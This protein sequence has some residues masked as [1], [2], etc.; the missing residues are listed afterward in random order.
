MIVIGHMGFLMFQVIPNGP[1][2]GT[3]SDV[4]SPSSVWRSGNAHEA[5]TVDYH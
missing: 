1:P 2:A 4:S 3:E 5:E